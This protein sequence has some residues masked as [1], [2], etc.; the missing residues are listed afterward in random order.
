M[1]PSSWKLILKSTFLSKYDHFV[2]KLRL[3]W[4][5]LGWECGPIWHDLRT[6]KEGIYV[7]KAIIGT[8]QLAYKWPLPWELRFERSFFRK[9]WPY[10]QPLLGWKCEYVCYNVRTEKKA[11]KVKGEHIKNN[12]P[13]SDL[14]LRN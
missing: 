3:I 1:W 5:L 4:T 9:I 8:K 12:L 2:S 13:T 14:H 10:F 11:F 6:E 7:K